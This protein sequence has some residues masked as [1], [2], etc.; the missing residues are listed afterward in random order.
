MK[1]K[2]RIL[3]ALKIWLV[4]YPSITAFLFLFS[5]QLAGLQLYVKTFVLTVT[6]VPWMMFVGLPAVEMILRLLSSKP[7][8]NKK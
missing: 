5:E 4:I 7:E 8:A 1:T 6:L 3:A 2:A